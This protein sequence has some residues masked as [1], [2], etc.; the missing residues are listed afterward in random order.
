MRGSWYQNV[1]TP[2]RVARTGTAPLYYLASLD[3]TILI[4]HKMHG[5]LDC[6]NQGVQGGQEARWGGLHRS[7]SWRG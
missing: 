1:L 5:G 3:G 2:Y 4:N 7:P 6:W